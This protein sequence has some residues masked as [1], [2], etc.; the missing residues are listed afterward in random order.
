MVAA[1]RIARRKID[2]E[3]LKMAATRI[4]FSSADWRRAAP[5]CRPEG[6]NGV[7][8]TPPEIWST[9]V[10]GAGGN[11]PTRAIMARPAAIGLV[12]ADGVAPGVQ[13]RH[14]GMVP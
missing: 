5:A 10:A 11:V 2:F 4:W 9:L 8:G 6:R 3:G 1:N 14:D 7:M 12:L 13:G